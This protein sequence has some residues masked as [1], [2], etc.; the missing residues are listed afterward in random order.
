MAIHAL[1]AGRGVPFDRISYN[2]VL[3]ARI[4]TGALVIRLA[5]GGEKH[6]ATL[7]TLW[8]DNIQVC[9]V[10]RP[11]FQSN[12]PAV[13]ELCSGH[14]CEHPLEPLGSMDLPLLFQAMYLIVDTK[15][16]VYNSYDHLGVV[17]LGGSPSVC[18]IIAISPAPQVG[19]LYYEA[20]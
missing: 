4:P 17:W 11:L 19:S 16:V 13:F 2:M 18:R 8:Q 9:V 15:R 3:W 20:I 6:M 14:L 1:L 7:A 12:V 10:H 5:V